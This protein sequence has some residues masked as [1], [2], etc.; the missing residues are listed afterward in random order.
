MKKTIK[1]QIE[2]DKAL[3]AKWGIKMPVYAT[4]SKRGL[5]FQDN[6]IVMDLIKNP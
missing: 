4:S 5:D 3:L 1:Q 2:T 6:S